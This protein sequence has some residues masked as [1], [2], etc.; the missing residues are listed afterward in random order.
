MQ[1]PDSG[2]LAENTRRKEAQL[3]TISRAPSP[4]LGPWR[5]LS[6][7]AC[8]GSLSDMGQERARAWRMSRVFLPLH[9]AGVETFAGTIISFT[10]RD[11]RGLS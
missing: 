6:A 8:R 2:G 9:G 5:A 10:H 7:L 3:A 4:A 1:L 11:F